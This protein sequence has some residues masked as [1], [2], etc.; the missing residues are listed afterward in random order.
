MEFRKNMK[1]NHKKKLKKLGH[2][3]VKGGRESVKAV[4]KYGPKVHSAARRMSDTTMDMMMPQ[5]TRTV[6][7]LTAKKVPKR[8]VKG[9][10]RGDFYLDFT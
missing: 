2:L 4:Q 7:D 3:L 9:K 1:P 10:R 6:V 8:V 5:R